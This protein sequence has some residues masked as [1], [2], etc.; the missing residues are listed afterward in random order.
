MLVASRL[1]Q[2]VRKILGTTVSHHA[3]EGFTGNI[4]RAYRDVM[5]ENLSGIDFPSFLSYSIKN[6]EIRLLPSLLS[7]MQ[8][9]SVCLPWLSV[10][11]Q[12]VTRPSF[13]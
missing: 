4:P 2:N 11:F 5:I 7:T 8:R 3:A 1:L 12:T 13:R 6:N 9:M 10:I